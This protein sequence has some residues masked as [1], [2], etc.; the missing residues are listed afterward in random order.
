MRSARHLGRPAASTL[1]YLAALV[2]LAFL[3]QQH[4]GLPGLS[5]RAVVTELLCS[6][7]QVSR[8]RTWRLPLSC[9]QVR[10]PKDLVFIEIDE[11]GVAHLGG[12]VPR[13]NMKQSQVELATMLMK[14][15]ASETPPTLSFGVFLKA[16][17]ACRAEEYPLGVRGDEAYLC[18]L[19][20]RLGRRHS[21]THQLSG[22]HRQYLVVAGGQE[23][24][25]HQVE[26]A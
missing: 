11:G 25:G 22:G 10:W 13:E 15:C 9:E 21:R 26:Q 23:G 20:R 16:V 24:C 5:D 18:E 19:G 7:I 4:G 1:V 12:L 6:L 14:R 3:S 2:R 8:R 17:V